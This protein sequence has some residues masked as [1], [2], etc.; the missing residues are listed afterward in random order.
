MN[1]WLIKLAA[2]GAPSNMNN[3]DKPMMPT[4]GSKVATLLPT[5]GIPFSETKER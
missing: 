1:L 2:S 3:V 4:F 5:K